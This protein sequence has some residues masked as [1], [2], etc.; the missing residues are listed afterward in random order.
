MPAE[1][2]TNPPIGPFRT[3]AWAPGPVALTPRIR[4][5]PPIPPVGVTS[6]PT[7]FAPVTVMEPAEMVAAAV[8]VFWLFR[9]NPAWIFP[10]GWWRP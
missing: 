7:V 10:A 6:R 9:T 1:M 3:T 5:L 8:L 4:T 2:S